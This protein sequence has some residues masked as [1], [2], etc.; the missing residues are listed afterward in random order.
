MPS[1]WDSVDGLK[2]VSVIFHDALLKVKKKIEQG[3][4]ADSYDIADL[5][6]TNHKQILLDLPGVIKVEDFR[7][8]PGSGNSDYAL[9]DADG[10]T[11]NSN[12]VRASQA[13]YE[14]SGFNSVDDAL[15]TLG[16][17]SY[18]A[19]FQ[20]TMEHE[21]AHVKNHHEKM[22]DGGV[23]LITQ[24]DSPLYA[25]SGFAV[26]RKIRNDHSDAPEAR[27]LEVPIECIRR[28]W[29]A[30]VGL[31]HGVF[32]IVDGKINVEQQGNPVTM[33]ELRQHM[34][35]AAIQKEQEDTTGSVD[36]VAGTL[37]R[38]R[39]GEDAD[40]TGQNGGG[41]RSA[42]KRERD[43]EDADSTGQSGGGK[44]NGS[45]R[46]RSSPFSDAPIS[47]TGHENSPQ[48]S[49]PSAARRS[50]WNGK[51]GS[52]DGEEELHQ[53]YL[54]LKEDQ[55]IRTLRKTA[56]NT[57]LQVAFCNKNGQQRESFAPS[58][59][60]YV[61]LTFMNPTEEDAYVVLHRKNFG[62]GALT[63]S[64]EE[65]DER[66]CITSGR[67]Q[68]V[69]AKISPGMSHTFATRKLCDGPKMESS[70]NANRNLEMVPFWTPAKEGTYYFTVRGW[71]GS[72]PLRISGDDKESKPPGI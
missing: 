11:F 57:S 27:I 71:E 55:K 18:S 31:V 2:N 63:I 14:E 20:E 23:T 50:I 8:F 69:V 15:D 40:S 39:D 36:G 26:Q 72:F 59:E 65:E 48:T 16:G 66:Y 12:L 21:L 1:I 9:T 3:S 5:D 38:D 58:D 60:V 33:D 42:L 49:A 28:N 45:S 25:E 22:G 7:S 10:I 61:Q 64:L 56:H 6:G 17:L 51:D 47:R 4:L 46:A 62:R 44:R 24:P 54:T 43:G 32:D 19:V 68:Y 34:K 37:K 30:P 67:D 70:T 53:L 41:K 13:F 35:Y 29:R 52:D